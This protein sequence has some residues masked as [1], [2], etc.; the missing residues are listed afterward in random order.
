MVLIIHD[1]SRRAARKHG[2][3][4]TFMATFEPTKSWFPQIRGKYVVYLR[5]SYRPHTK[6]KLRVQRE[7][8]DELLS[9]GRAHRVDECVEFEPLVR[10]ARPALQRAIQLAEMNDA[11]LIFGSFDRM[12]GARR[13]LEEIWKHQIKVRAADLPHWTYA[14]FSRFRDQDKQRCRE[15]SH[16]VRLA[17]ASA[18]ERG[19]VLGGKRTNS[20]GLQKGPIESAMSRSKKARQRDL[21]TMGEIDLIY[22]NGTRSLTDVAAQLNQLGHK[23]PRGGKWSAAQVRRVIQNCKK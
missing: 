14:E 4:F 6:L 19:A 9:K 17:L 1:F 2:L 10:G 13:W 23:A 21:Q 18:K 3:D 22:R 5:C 12:R 20:H 8:V 7:A 11:T 15:I 16:Q